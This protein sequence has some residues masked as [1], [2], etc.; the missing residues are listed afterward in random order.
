M[1]DPGMKLGREIYA[2]SLPGFLQV[3]GSI[4]DDR[5]GGI[6]E[7]FSANVHQLMDRFGAMPNTIVHFDY[8][9]D[10]L[11]FDDTRDGRGG[12]TMIDF[13]AS[14][15]GGG[16]YDVGYF[17]SQNVETDVRREHEEDLLR[18][19][20]ETLRAGGVEGYSLDHLRADYRVGVLYGW[21]IPVFAV[22]T[23]DSSSERA[24]A[25]W[26]EVIRRAQAALL[27]HEVESLLT[28]AS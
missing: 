2:A 1:D 6:V 22:G 8:R 12:V 24:M 21:I 3:F 13:Q 16:A 20:H 15:K 26:T 17:L 5:I 10:N 4:L 28:E 9:L 19:Y 25:L 27:D 7:R 11:F 18:L 14:S 23:L